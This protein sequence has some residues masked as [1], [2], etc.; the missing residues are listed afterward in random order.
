MKTATEVIDVIVEAKTP[1]LKAKATRFLRQY[2]TQQDKLG[3]K[4]KHT[5][6]AIKAVITRDRNSKHNG[7]I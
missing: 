7:I 1:E 5:R 2:V 4:P 6:A 3:H